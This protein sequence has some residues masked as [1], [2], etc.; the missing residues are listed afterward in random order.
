VKWFGVTVMLGLLVVS[1]AWGA[2]SARIRLLATKPLA[3]AGTGFA[4]NDTVFV[5]A[6]VGLKAAR[7]SI[8]SDAT[9]AWRV[10]FSALRT[11]RCGRFSVVAVDSR[12]HRARL[13]VATSCGPV[14]P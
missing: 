8:R 13:A 7:A 11:R 6:T 2:S 1:V 5:E 3:V 4:V 10:T 14:N 12:N 9:G